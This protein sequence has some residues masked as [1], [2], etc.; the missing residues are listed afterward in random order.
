[1]A[2]NLTIAA[3]NCNLLGTTADVQDYVHRTIGPT[4]QQQRIAVRLHLATPTSI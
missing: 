4:L 1:M 3:R 2:E